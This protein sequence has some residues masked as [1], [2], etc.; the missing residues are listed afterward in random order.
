MSAIGSVASH[1]AFSIT[2]TQ[3][4]I[5]KASVYYEDTKFLC[6]DCVLSVNAGSLDIE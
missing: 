6:S 5:Y 2:P 3:A 1:L 4:C